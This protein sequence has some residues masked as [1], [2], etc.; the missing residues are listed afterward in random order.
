MMARGPPTWP[1]TAASLGLVPLRPVGA[2]FPVLRARAVRRDSDLG[3]RSVARRIGG[4]TVHVVAPPSPI[5]PLRRTPGE[6]ATVGPNAGAFFFPA[7][8]TG[9]A[10]VGCRVAG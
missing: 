1:R 9:S 10:G 4:F 5:V 3:T 2:A 6:S 8:A 7:V